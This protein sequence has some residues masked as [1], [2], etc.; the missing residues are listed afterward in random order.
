MNQTGGVV[1]PAPA[2][3]EQ[4]RL[5][6]R[7]NSFDLYDSSGW[8]ASVA[9]QWK[10]KVYPFSSHLLFIRK[11]LLRKYLRATNQKFV[12]VLWGERNFSGSS[13][14]HQDQSLSDIWQSH[15]YVHKKMFVAKI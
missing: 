10:E 14:L 9:V 1:V 13:G 2:L 11:S 15:N 8:R 7:G 12:W 5:R 4:L 6:E 3:C